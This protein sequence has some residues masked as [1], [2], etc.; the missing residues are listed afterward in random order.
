MGLG[1]R[2]QEKSKTSYKLLRV[3]DVNEAITR[4]GLT[5]DVEKRSP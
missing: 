2:F 4:N 1:L 5:L 3:W